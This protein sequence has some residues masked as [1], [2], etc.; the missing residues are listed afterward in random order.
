M[1]SVCH[2]FDLYQMREVEERRKGV[3]YAEHVRHR[4]GL[5]DDG[6]ELV[7]YKMRVKPARE[8]VIHVI[9]EELFLYLCLMFI[10]VQ[11]SLTTGT[12]LIVSNLHPNVSDRDIMVSL[13]YFKNRYCLMTA[14]VIH[15]CRSY[16]R[17]WVN[18]SLPVSLTTALLK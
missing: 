13:V 3:R 15:S 11:L 5:E 1:F 8:E 2:L 18:C 17:Q 7:S 12:R 9:T 14:I 16:L 6:S 4:P 10:H